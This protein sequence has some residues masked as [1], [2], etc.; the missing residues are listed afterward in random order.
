MKDNRQDR[1]LELIVRSYIEEK[2]PIGSKKLQQIYEENLSPATLRNEMQKLEEQ[3]YLE[4]VHNSSGR[5][6][7]KKGYE[8][9]LTTIS[10]RQ[11][12]PDINHYVSG[13]VEKYRLNEQTIEDTLEI[14]A[15]ISNFAI[16]EK[17]LSNDDSLKNLKVIPLTDEEAI[18][19]II[20]KF[21]KIENQKV[22]IPSD[23]SQEQFVTLIKELE[24]MLIGIKLSN[25]S[26]H[27]E[28]FIAPKIKEYINAYH[29]FLVELTTVFAKITIENMYLKGAS[30]IFKNSDFKSISTI[31]D[32]STMFLEEKYRMFINNVENNNQLN[33]QIIDDKVSIFSLPKVDN[34]QMS[35][36]TPT[37]VDYEKVM[38]LLNYVISQVKEKNGNKN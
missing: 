15:K 11:I 18:L 21:E 23:I 34:K 20:T 36:I 12:T 25:L 22:K 6:P 9:Y 24:Q 31:Q 28:N 30:N 17:D 16:V 33:I 32:I 19:I 37:R 5:I 38:G 13:I 27:L 7:S 3:G 4:K 29:L 1:L 35:L 26:N 10:N 2:V 8:Q 14:V